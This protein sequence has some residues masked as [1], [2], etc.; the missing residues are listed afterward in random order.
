MNIH[1]LLDQINV[2]IETISQNGGFD[3]DMEEGVH[4]TMEEIE[5]MNLLSDYLL[6]TLREIRSDLEWF[7]EHPDE[8][9]NSL[10]HVNHKIMAAFKD[11]KK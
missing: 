3:L 11:G 5:E 10:G 9:P 1:S 6:R 4:Y 2:A 7:S 8:E